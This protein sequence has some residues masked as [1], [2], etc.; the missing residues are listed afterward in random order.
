[1]IAVL[2]CAG[3][4]TRMYPLTEHHPKHLLSVSGKPVLNYF[5][6][7]L[8]ELEGLRSVHVVTNARF[9][10][11]FENWKAEW[12]NCFHSAPFELEVHNDGSTDND[13]RLGTSADLAWALKDAPEFSRMLV[14]AGD[15]IFRFKIEPL[16]NRF[17]HSRSHWI[18]ALPESDPNRLMR[19]GVL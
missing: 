3:Y 9:V 14:A 17:L 8:L 5:M 16:W 15:N 1:M 12:K 11:Q 2:L 18:V 13:N 10:S 7:Q 4:A 19:T 6:E